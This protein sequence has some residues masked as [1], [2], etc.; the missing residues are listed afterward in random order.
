MKFIFTYILLLVVIGLTYSQ[1]IG[2]V[3]IGKSYDESA[4]ELIGE[5]FIFNNNKI[6][7]LFQTY[8]GTFNR[9]SIVER[10]LKIEDKSQT[11]YSSEKAEIDPDWDRYW[12]YYTLP[13]GEYQIK[14][15]DES[16]E[17]L[18]KSIIFL[19]Y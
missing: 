18:G 13:N 3:K 12:S 8:T 7:M 4:F 17:L 14:I 1:E 11:I 10:I 5:S 9:L 19:I 15:Y 2:S 16:G 6:C